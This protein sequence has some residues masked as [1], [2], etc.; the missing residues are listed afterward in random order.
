MQVF[1]KMLMVGT[2]TGVSF[3]STA[4]QKEG[5]SLIMIFSEGSSY[6]SL[7]TQNYPWFSLLT[8]YEEHQV[9]Y[10]TGPW[11]QM[12]TLQGDTVQTLQKCIWAVQAEIGS[13]QKANVILK[14]SMTAGQ[15]TF[16]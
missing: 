7:R 16:M 10:R 13:E 5:Y 3:T 12:S 8:G 14:N 9:Q 15:D 4:G 2:K 11:R 1:R 6:S